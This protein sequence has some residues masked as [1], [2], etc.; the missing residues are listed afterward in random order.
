[1]YYNRIR[2][3][4]DISEA[5]AFVLG[6]GYGLS[7]WGGAKAGAAVGTVFFPIIGTIVG[8]ILG[9]LAA[10]YGY[11]AIVDWVRSSPSPIYGQE[12]HDEFLDW[13]DENC[14]H[15]QYCPRCSTGQ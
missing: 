3:K 11:N 7:I 5:G 9:A 13:H 12:L 1:M 14:H 10:T 2:E 15:P 6:V 4:K 8:G